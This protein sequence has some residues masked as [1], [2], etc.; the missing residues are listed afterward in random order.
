MGAGAGLLFAGQRAWNGD[1]TGAA[2]ELASG[3]AGTIPGVGTAASMALDAGLMARDLARENAPDH[4]LAGADT[5]AQEVSKAEANKG[6]VNFTYAPKINAPGGD[7]KTI[8]DLLD[9]DKRELHK[10]FLKWMAEYNQKQL[11][12]SLGNA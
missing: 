4:G 9:K 10:L 12:T 11:R 8:K 6:Q 2:G 5:L 7:P 3:L 1:W